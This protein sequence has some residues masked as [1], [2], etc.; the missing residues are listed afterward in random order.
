MDLLDPKNLK[1]LE[2][3]KSKIRK[4]KPR[5]CEYKLGLPYVRNIDYMNISNN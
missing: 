5:K 1:D 4:W 2:M 3:S